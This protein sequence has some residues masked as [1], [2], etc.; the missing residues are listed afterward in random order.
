MSASDDSGSDRKIGTAKLPFTPGP[1]NLNDIFSAAATGLGATGELS[2]V[3]IFE[4]Q[5]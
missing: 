5:M 2:D 1:R 3:A 4:V